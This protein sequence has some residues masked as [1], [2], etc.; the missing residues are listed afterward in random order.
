MQA[1]N[2]EEFVLD[3]TMDL[4][5]KRAGTVSDLDAG[6]VEICVSAA[7]RVFDALVKL[8]MIEE[9]DPEEEEEGDGDT[10]E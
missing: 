2:R 8:E 3:L 7:G 1:V 9:G 10:D 4:L 5:M 6:A